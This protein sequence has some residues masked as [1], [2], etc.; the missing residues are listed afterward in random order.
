MFIDSVNKLKQLADVDLDTFKNNSNF[1]NLKS[2]NF[3][4]L[5][6][7][8]LE[9]GVNKENICIDF[10]LTRNL[11]YYNGVVFDLIYKDK[12]IGGGGRYDDLPAMLG[13]KEDI[14]CFGFAIDISKL[15]DILSTDEW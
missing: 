10:S 2:E 5:I 6:D 12:L 13:Y 4:N 15:T 11:A 1:N 9:K 3:N 14:C 7:K 8:L